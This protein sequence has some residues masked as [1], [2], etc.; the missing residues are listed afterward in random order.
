[1]TIDRLDPAE[2]LRQ[3]GVYIENHAHEIIGDCDD[4]LLG[5][6]DV[7]IHLAPDELTVIHVSKDIM[8]DF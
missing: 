1:M 3:C 2:N 6:V 8:P 5:S 7:T 4:L